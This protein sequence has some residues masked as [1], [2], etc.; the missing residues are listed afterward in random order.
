MSDKMVGKE[1][2]Y[3]FWFPPQGIAEEDSQWHETWM[4]QARKACRSAI[5]RK[6][7]SKDEDRTGARLQFPGTHKEVSVVVVQRVQAVW[8]KRIIRRELYLVT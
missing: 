8:W 4:N 3:F 1:H 7:G 2:Q 6:R 5:W